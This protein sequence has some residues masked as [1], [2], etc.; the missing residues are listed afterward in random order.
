[1]FSFLFRIVL[2][3]KISGVRSVCETCCRESSDLRAEA[4]TTEE[5]VAVC[6]L[7]LATAVERAVVSVVIVGSMAVL[8]LYGFLAVRAVTALRA[9]C[10]AGC[11]TGLQDLAIL[12]ENGADDDIDVPDVAERA[13]SEPVARASTP[14]RP[15]PVRRGMESV[16]TPWTQVLD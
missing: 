8:L 6:P 14:V 11:R 2:L 13:C 5:G 15:G 3:E 10:R 1:M 9:Y 4:P 12:L 16:F 7:G